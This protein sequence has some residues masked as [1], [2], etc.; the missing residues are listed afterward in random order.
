MERSRVRDTIAIIEALL[1]VGTA[2]E[3]RRPLP[4]AA[5]PVG[6]PVSTVALPEAT[7]TTVFLP[8]ETIEPSPT[9]IIPLQER[10][11]VGTNLS[12]SLETLEGEVE[13]NIFPKLEDA[14]SSAEFDS[15]TD[16][17]A[18]V[19][20]EDLYGNMIFLVH[21]GYANRGGDWQPLPAEALR[22]YIQGDN[23]S[24]G[25]ATLS[26]EEQQK[27]IEALAGGRVTVTTSGTT[28]NF[29]VGAAQMVERKD[30]A[31]FRRD[32]YMVV[33]RLAQ[34]EVAGRQTS[35]F[36][37]AREGDG[38]VMIVSL[39][40]QEGSTDPEKWSYE[41]LALFIYPED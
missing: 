36:G 12:L 20:D 25:L 31:D 16:N 1:I 8:T 2:C 22:A 10:V 33:D 13:I 9:P 23:G 11:P 26:V 41:A 38:I 3:G 40:A 32:T 28:Q 7:A 30:M 24:G 4:V 17:I 34:Y 29:R 15:F 27:K 6:E 14:N 37:V 39:R 35:P 18:L 21:S 5:T 19:I